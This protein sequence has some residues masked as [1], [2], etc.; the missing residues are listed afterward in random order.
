[1]IRDSVSIVLCVRNEALLGLKYE[2]ILRY[3]VT[4]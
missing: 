2:L 3:L 1:M 4:L